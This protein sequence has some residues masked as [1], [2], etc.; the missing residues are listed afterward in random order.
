MCNQVQAQKNTNFTD[1]YKSLEEK[2]KSKLN[3]QKTEQR[4]TKKEQLKKGVLYLVFFWPGHCHLS[5]WFFCSGV[6]ASAAF[7]SG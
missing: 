2:I 7:F 4:F 1:T 3:V 6:Y 5:S